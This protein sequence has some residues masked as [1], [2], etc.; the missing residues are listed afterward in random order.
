MAENFAIFDFEPGHDDF[1]QIVALDEKASCFF[2]H[3]DPEFLKGLGT[4]KLGRRS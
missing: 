3:R 1:A 4:R 2:D